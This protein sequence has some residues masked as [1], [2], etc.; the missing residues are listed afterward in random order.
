MIGT[1]VNGSLMYSW[2][3]PATSKLPVKTSMA[4][5]ASAAV[6]VSRFP[7]DPARAVKLISSHS[8]GLAWK[9]MRPRPSRVPTPRAAWLFLVAFVVIA[10]AT[11]VAGEI[12][13]AAFP[14]G[15]SGV[16]REGMEFALDL[17]SSSLTRVAMALTSA[18]DSE[19]VLLVLGTAL[20]AAAIT[21]SR[22]WAGFFSL[23]IVGAFGIHSLVKPLLGRARPD[24][25]PLVDIGGY[26]FPSGHANAGAVLYGALFVVAIAR[27]GRGGAAIAGAICILI[28]IGVGLSRVYL[29]VHWPT[30]IVAGTVAGATWVYVATRLSGVLS[31]GM[32]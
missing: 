31:D 4:S 1:G 11:Y 6:L 16:D 8:G 15:V 18:G 28:G 3:K 32:G 26:S 10:G 30:D 9:I 25:A 24:L 22:P 27:W 12:L 14:N 5:I 7:N 17:R 23:A 21:R 29:G 2:A 19:V 20:A 13:L